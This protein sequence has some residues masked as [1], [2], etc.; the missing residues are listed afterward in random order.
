MTDDNADILVSVT[1]EEIEAERVTEYT[2][3]TSSLLESVAIYRKIALMLPSY[4]A[5]LL[6][7]AA[8][9][10]DGCAYAFAAKSGTGKSTHIAQWRK[11]FGERVTIINGDKPIVR[12]REGIPVIYGTPWA[13]KEHWQRNTYA[14]LKAICFIERAEKN[15]IRRLLFAD[16]ASRLMGQILHSADNEYTDKLLSLTVGMIKKI[17]VYLL[18]CDVSE[19]AAHVAYDE[20][21]KDG[22]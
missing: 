21:K 11:A 12:M 17:P 19:E 18:G 3:A 14:P 10:M 1:D 15:A 5:F 7:A 2:S 4:D 22:E 20:M 16:A 6:H 8:I 9:E 13:G